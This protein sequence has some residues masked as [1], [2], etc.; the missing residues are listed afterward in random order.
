MAV[1][2]SLL[3]HLGLPS[4]AAVQPRV[5]FLR[6]NAGVHEMRWRFCKSREGVKGTFVK[7]RGQLGLVCYHQGAGAA[8]Q[9]RL[10][11]MAAAL[12][13][14]MCCTFGHCSHPC[15]CADQSV[16]FSRNQPHGQRWVAHGE[17]VGESVRSNSNPACT[18]C[19]L[20]AWLSTGLPLHPEAP[21]LRGTHPLT[22]PTLAP[23]QVE[24]EA[25]L[26]PGGP[27]SRGIPPGQERH[28]S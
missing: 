20:G 24:Y 8:A 5:T 26:S 21:P 15:C 23:W 4:P 3:V 10:P 18:L 19:K 2:P 16:P 1:G 9:P 17:H 25:L 11:C 6:A 27:Y 7:V 28:L 12:G 13:L 22:G 14:A